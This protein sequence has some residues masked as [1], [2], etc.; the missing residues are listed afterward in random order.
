MNYWN[1][2]TPE[3]R[4]RVC[5]AEGYNSVESFME[6]I[7]RGGSQYQDFPAQP[8]CYQGLGYDAHSSK[9]AIGSSIQTSS[10]FM[11]SKQNYQNS[12][13]R[14]NSKIR[15]LLSVGEN[16]RKRNPTHVKDL[17]Q[18]IG[19]GHQKIRESVSDSE[20]E[21]ENLRWAKRTN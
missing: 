11:D 4:E 5:K 21:D 10:S 8:S 15:K 19:K 7:N 1:P 16:N 14:G 18:N 13:L 9:K 3:L 2:Y 17:G 20:T 6:S 12:K